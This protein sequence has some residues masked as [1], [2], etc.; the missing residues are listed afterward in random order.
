MHFFQKFSESQQ[1]ANFDKKYTWKCKSGHEP[2][3]RQS[4]LK[5]TIRASLALAHNNND[6]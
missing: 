5:P 3:H 6:T 1:K 4:Q 2:K